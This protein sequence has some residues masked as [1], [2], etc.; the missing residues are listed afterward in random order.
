MRERRIQNNRIR[1][2]KELR[3][4]ILLFI[5][6]I[7]CVCS[8]SLSAGS[9]LSNAEAHNEETAFKFYASVPVETGDT[10]WSIAE[11]RM[12]SHY[13]SVE[14]YIKEICRINALD[15]EE[16]QAGRYLVVPYYAVK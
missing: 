7:C 10:L 4:N 16:I 6:T 14:D 8:L 1:R 11:T 13:E 12:D 3:K 15:S 9:L 2:K 5:M